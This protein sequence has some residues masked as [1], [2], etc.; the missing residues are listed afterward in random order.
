MLNWFHNLSLMR[1]LL[2]TGLP[3][4]V[5]FFT[6]V[7][8]NLH[9]TQLVAEIDNELESLV[10]L[11]S[12]L[13][14]LGFSAQRYIQGIE[15]NDRQNIAPRGAKLRDSYQSL[16]EAHGWLRTGHKELY[17]GLMIITEFAQTLLATPATDPARTVALGEKFTDEILAFN[18]TLQQVFVETL[19]HKQ[20]TQPNFTRIVSFVIPGILLIFL[21]ALL[22]AQWVFILPLKRFVRLTERYA[23]GELSARAE[24]KGSDELGLLATA[25]NRMAATIQKS[26][27]ELEYYSTRD[28]LTGI[29]NNRA[30]TERLLEEIA[31]QRRNATGVFSLVMADIDNFKS[32]N[33][34]YGH[35]AGDQVLREAADFMKQEARTSDFVARYGGEEFVMLLPDTALDGAVRFARRLQ[36]GMATLPVRIG[37]D[38][39]LHLTIS[40]G[41]A[42]YPTQG[43]SIEAL[44]RAADHYLYMAKHHGRNRA[45]F[46]GCPQEGSDQ[47]G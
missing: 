44:I 2:M 15:H 26:Q 6:I 12:G 10:V 25:F 9:R 38:N 3:V 24:I 39:P 46:P 32:I 28:G 14:E 19:A 33:D 20:Q 8:W 37:A 45:C 43:D 35:P 42:A 23:A 27:A 41:V 7:F 31:R 47:T 40:L 4:V 11:R 22:V 34:T 5:T 36:E 21:S 18:V 30:F 29:Y 13:L 17:S 16:L 1:K